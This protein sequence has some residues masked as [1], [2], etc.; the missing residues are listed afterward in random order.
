MLNQD[1][2]EF[3]LWN[4]KPTSAEDFVAVDSKNNVV[5]QADFCSN[6]AKASSTGTGAAGSQNTSPAAIK[7]DSSSKKLSGGAIAGIAI[8]SVAFLAALTALVFFVLARKR[9][10]ANAAAKE[11]PADSAVQQVLHDPSYGYFEPQKPQELSAKQG[12]MSPTPTY[13]PPVQLD[14]TEAMVRQELPG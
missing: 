11:L 10:N 3:T 5:E 4:A 1:T 2:D 12:V 9:K 6:K 7:T 13:S 8:G 14:A